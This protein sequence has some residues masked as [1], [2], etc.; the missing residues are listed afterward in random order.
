MTSHLVRQRQPSGYRAL[1][2]GRVSCPGMAYLLT[3][4]TRNRRP[5]FSEFPV[6][7]AAARCFNDRLLLRDSCMLAW[8]LMPDHAHWLIQLGESDD[9]SSLVNRLKSASSRMAGKI[10]SAGGR[11]WMPGFHDSGIRSEKALM[12]AARYIVANPLRAGLVNRVG[13]YPFWDVMWL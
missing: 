4:V 5:V 9:L 2:K 6:A 10:C 1:R 13:D 8:V 7:C 3:S 12:A 11:L